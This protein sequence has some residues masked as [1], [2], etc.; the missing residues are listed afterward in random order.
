MCPQLGITAQEHPR[1]RRLHSNFGL[2][3]C[4]TL[5]I[6]SAAYMYKMLDEIISDFDAEVDD[7]AE[8]TDEKRSR[9]NSSELKAV[10]DQRGVLYSSLL[11]RRDVEFAV[12]STGLITSSELKTAEAKQLEL[13]NMNFSNSPDAFLYR[14]LINPVH[15][16]LNSN[17]LSS[18][19]T[20]ISIIF[21]SESEFIEHVEDKKDSVW[22]LAVASPRSVENG[23]RIPSKIKPTSVVSEEVWAVLNHRYQS[24]GFK[25]GLLNCKKLH[26][27]CIDRGF[28][29][30]DLILA[31]PKGGERMKDMVQFR[32]LPKEPKSKIN[33]DK[34][35]MV[36]SNSIYC[37][38]LKY[39]KTNSNNNM[40]RSS[41]SR[42]LNRL[43]PVL[44][45]ERLNQISPDQ[46]WNELSRLIIQ[47]DIELKSGSA[48]STTSSTLESD[49]HHRHYDLQMCNDET[50]SVGKQIPLTV[51]TLK[52]VA[53]N[54]EENME[55]VEGNRLLRRLRRL[56]HILS[57]Q[58][59][60]LT[61]TSMDPVASFTSLDSYYQGGRENEESNRIT[62]AHMYTWNCLSSLDNSNNNIKSR[63]G[64]NPDR[65]YRNRRRSGVLHPTTTSSQSDL[66]STDHEAYQTSRFAHSRKTQCNTLMSGGCISPTSSTSS[67]SSNDVNCMISSNDWPSWVVPCKECVVCW[68]K[69]RSGVRLSALPC[70]HGF[71]EH[72]IRKWLDTGA[73]DCPVCR[74]P[75]YAPHLRQQCQMIEQLISAVQKTVNF[76]KHSKK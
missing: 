75:A 7:L 60:H 67:V 34:K 11:E 6:C 57:Q 41:Y 9:L 73:F 39:K 53:N 33:A 64:V 4:F 25:M 19:F 5:S 49:H 31:L 30:P 72:C 71:H 46:L 15:Q 1:F 44:V 66:D 42:R 12:N 74:W 16:S 51:E 45:R 20:P 2:I 54:P 13:V 40:P 48:D 36:S 50:K 17:R 61:S 55:V 56:Y 8:N 76:A 32:P 38:M 62:A 27:L 14:K 18:S 23:D 68:Q 47:S 35:S 37:L 52:Q 28:I 10:L 59:S 26:S 24:F 63:S 29:N 70:G 58:T 43:D 69:F 65:R 21:D 3:T 22:L